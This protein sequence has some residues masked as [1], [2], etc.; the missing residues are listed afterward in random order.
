M[1]RSV[2]P[3]SAGEEGDDGTFERKKGSNAFAIRRKK[4]RGHKESNVCIEKKGKGGKILACQEDSGSMTRELTI[5]KGL[6]WL[7][8]TSLQGWLDRNE[9]EKVMAKQFLLTENAC[10][11]TASSH[12]SRVIR[13]IVDEM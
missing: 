8:N 12:I 6:P 4:G 13:V 2:K 5:P 1:F 9:E 7:G 3:L 11:N 10:R